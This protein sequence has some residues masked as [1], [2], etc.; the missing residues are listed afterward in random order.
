MMTSPA[1]AGR[2]HRLRKP[3]RFNYRLHRGP[4][5]VASGTVTGDALPVAV[6]QVRSAMLLPAACTA[7]EHTAAL[8]APS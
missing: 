6:P 7:V 5:R 4:S 3:G 2:T 8:K 1:T